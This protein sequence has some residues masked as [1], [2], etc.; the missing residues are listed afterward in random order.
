ML[1]SSEAA[2]F[3]MLLCGGLALVLMAMHHSNAERMQRL[4]M[5]EEGLRDPKLDA[6]T[7]QQLIQTLTAPQSL[8]GSWRAWL[9]DNLV[10]RR[11]FIG[12]S[13]MAMIIGVLLA[14]FGGHYDR[15]PGIAMASIGMAVLALPL[16]VRELEARAARR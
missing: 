9:R 11:V 16:V 7:R 4:R 8:A 1:A 10:P 14:T 12:A 15:M 13:W 5:L 6:V 2:V 3:F